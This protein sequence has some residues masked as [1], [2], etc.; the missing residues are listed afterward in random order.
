[1]VD[2]A[3]VVWF[4]DGGQCHIFTGSKHR[5][6][7]QKRVHHRDSSESE[8]SRLFAHVQR[9]EGGSTGGRRKRG[10]AQRR[11][12]DAMNE[13]MQRGM[14]GWEDMQMTRYGAP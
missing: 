11:F 7:E 12:M 2:L 10:K 9:R 13:D 4:G 8:R 14:L 3:F 5:G 1:M 6:G